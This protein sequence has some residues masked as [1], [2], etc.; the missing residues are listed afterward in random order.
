LHEHTTIAAVD[1]GSN[2]FRL[3]VARVVDDQIYPLDSLKETVRLASGL[4]EDKTLDEEA[5]GRAITCLKRFNERLRG[6]PPD[7]VR[8]VGTNTFRVAK[9]AKSFL[10][11]AEAALG[12]PIEI[13]AG[14][15]E[16]RL[17]YLGVS[18]SLPVSNA[19]RLVVDIGGG[20]TEFIIGTRYEPEAMES[21]YMGC[22]TYSRRFF[23]EGKIS[24]NGLQA[25][26]LAAR[27]EVQTI[28][29]DFSV[30]HWDEAVGSSGTARALADIF[31][32]NGWSDGTITAQG[33]KQL[34]GI[35]LKAGD[36]G[37]L[38]LSGLQGDRVPVVAGGYAVMAGLFEELGIQ[39]MRVASG[40]LR[41]GVL[42][43]LVG[44]FH[45]H[46][47]REATVAQFKRRYHVD[48]QQVA[49]I[50][51]TAEQL[52][53]GL[54]RKLSPEEDEA[55]QELL[56]AV[57]LHEIGISIAHSGYHKHSAYILANAD[58]PGFSKREQARLALL[59]RAHRGA[60]AKGA[61]TV[62]APEEW[63]LIAVLRLAV[64]LNRS[65]TDVEAPP[66]SLQWKGGR[67]RLTV[68]RAWVEAN[69]LT[70]TLL[71]NE[72]AEWQSIGIA[73]DLQDKSP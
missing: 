15:E 7:A 43:D 59:V 47:Q 20:S 38:K 50:V 70:Q 55:K 32:Q 22:V 44:R 13:V 27:A 1:L 49:R 24:K 52:F 39:Q 30:G 34:R 67:F 37:N 51:R 19:R 10:K 23:P 4:R 73:M 18:H 14:K 42:Y 46:D 12:V 45:H 26:E 40:A 33:L 9:N 41:E 35:L 16:A 21:L 3:Q 71:E 5:Q 17:I 60:L 61:E 58:M 48:E 63:L 72:R 31:A 25:A 29:A 8:A 66:L 53:A 65:R 36:V 56:R 69:P 62:T 28:A 2:S 11:A 68:D 54:A 6:L 64:L 57:Q